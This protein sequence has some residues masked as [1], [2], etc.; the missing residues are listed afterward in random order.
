M[1]KLETSFTLPL[2]VKQ[3]WSFLREPAFVA[4]CIPG[5]KITDTG[6]D[7]M[8]TGEIQ[9]RFGPTVATFAGQV[10]LVYDDDARRCTIKA[11]GTDRKGASRAIANFDL[12]ARE[13][14]NGTHASLVGG[15]DVVGPLETFAKA[16]G[17]HLAKSLTEEFARNMATAIDTRSAAGTAAQT[18]A[19][20]D[21]VEATEAATRASAAPSTRT[22]L[23]I[24]WRGLRGW[25]SSMVKRRCRRSPPAR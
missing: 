14:G 25:L 7:D 1:I 15:F 11:S 10:Q 21:P 17:V 4:S 9:F 12:D 3:A 18:A 16:G 23:R 8:H 19:E 5:A 24:G 6:A 13:A 20:R 2:D 22:T